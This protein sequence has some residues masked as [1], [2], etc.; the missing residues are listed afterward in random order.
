[1]K[2]SLDATYSVGENLSGVGVYSRELLRALAA[3]HLEQ[4]F[5]LCYRP[6]RYT[7]SFG[8]AIPPNCSRALLL[9]PLFPRSREFFHGLNQRLP[10]IR[11]RKAVSTFH[12]LFVLTG[13]YSTPEFRRRFAAQARQAAAA[14]DAIIAVS[15]F[16]AR[17]VEQLLGVEP[18]RIQVVHHGANRMRLRQTI[19][20]ENIVLNVGAI[21]RRKNIARLVEAFERTPLRW[22]LVLAGSSGYGA[23]EIL[24]R[25]ESSPR[26]A[27]IQLLGYVSAEELAEWYARARIFAFPSLDEGFGMPVLEAMAAGTPVVAANRSALPEVCGD[28]A[29]LVDPEDVDAIYAALDQLMCDEALAAKMARR[30]LARANDFTWEKAA[31]QTWNVYRGA[32]G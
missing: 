19:E 24:A 4:Q 1:M 26:R 30:G 28:A 11:F 23:G 7:R 10:G 31:E 15:A 22:K 13:D 32:L 12:D 21:Q 8:I 17:Q 18:A 14:S 6:H 20:R 2:I 27:D 5:E 16:T 29:L 3:A 9:E 25:I